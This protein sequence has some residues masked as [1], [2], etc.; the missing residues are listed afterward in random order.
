MNSV[1]SYSRIQIRDTLHRDTAND[2]KEQRSIA[3]VE[4]DGIGAVGGHGNGI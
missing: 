4:A 3:P 1:R 2:L